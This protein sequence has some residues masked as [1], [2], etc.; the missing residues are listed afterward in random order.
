MDR[1][2]WSKEG[3]FLLA[4]LCSFQAF[5]TRVRLRDTNECFLFIINNF[6]LFFFSPWML[7]AL[8]QKQ[9]YLTYAVH[10]SHMGGI[11]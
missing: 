8:S 6:F 4:F 5:P 7:S 10:S 3:L 2:V 11:E 9:Y 1:N